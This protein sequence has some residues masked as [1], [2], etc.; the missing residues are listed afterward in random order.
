ML[1]DQGN[2]ASQEERRSDAW[3]ARERL[4]FHH[5]TEERLAG[6][7]TEEG[8]DLSKAGSLSHDFCTRMSWAP[9]PI[10]SWIKL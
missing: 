10:F 3:G 7:W 9:K 2:Q 1:R 4:C 5:E 8:Q 6:T